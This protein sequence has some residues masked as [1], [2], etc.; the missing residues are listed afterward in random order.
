MLIRD[1]DGLPGSSP[2]MQ[3]RL[4]NFVIN[5]LINWWQMVGNSYEYFVVDC[6]NTR[7]IC[8]LL[9]MVNYYEVGVVIR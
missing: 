3:R 4:Q 6:L 9:E 7:G 1:D 2:A 5:I 8:F